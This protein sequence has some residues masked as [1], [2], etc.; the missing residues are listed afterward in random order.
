L[1][2]GPRVAR[3]FW[4]LTPEEFWIEVECWSREQN[5][6]ADRM[7][8]MLCALKSAVWRKKRLKPKELLGRPLISEQRKKRRRA[9]ESNDD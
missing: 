8:V 7:A 1:D 2:I 5:Q 4:D 3:R 6:Q 9:T